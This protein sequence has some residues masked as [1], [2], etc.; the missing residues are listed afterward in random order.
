VAKIRHFVKKKKASNNMVKG[1]FWKIS[2]RIT[3]F[4]ER[5]YEIAK[6]FGGFGQIF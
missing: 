1:T 5:K 2:Q 4:Q 6:I 3:T